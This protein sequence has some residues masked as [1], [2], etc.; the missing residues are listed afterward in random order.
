MREAFFKMAEKLFEYLAKKTGRNVVSIKNHKFFAEIYRFKKHKAPYIKLYNHG[1]YCAGRTEIF[2]DMLAIK[3][4]IREEA[5]TWLQEGVTYDNILEKNCCA[6]DKIVDGYNKE[7]RA[8]GIPHVVIDK[9][10]E[11]HSPHASSLAKDIEDIISGNSFSGVKEMMH[12]IL[13]LHTYILVLTFRDAEKTLWELN[14]QLSGQTYKG[15]QM[16]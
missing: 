15:I 4:E 11:W 2:R 12:A 8:M 5:M 3:F 14:G 13:Y 7:R 10:N 6:I 1:V 9:F 16:I